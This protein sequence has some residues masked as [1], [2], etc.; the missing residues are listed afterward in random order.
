MQPFRVWFSHLGELRSLIP[1]VPMMAITA[2]SSRANRDKIQ[3]RLSMRNVEQVVDS[4]DRP[5]VKLSVESFA[6][7]EDLS[8]CFSWLLRQLTEQ[9]KICD[10]TVVFF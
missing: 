1:G 5:N 6:S 3:K 8:T 9:K 10:R 2:T 7:N 4:P